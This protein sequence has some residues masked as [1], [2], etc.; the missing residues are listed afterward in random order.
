MSQGEFSVEDLVVSPGMQLGVTPDGMYELSLCD[1]LGSGVMRGKALSPYAFAATVDFTCY[2]CP[3]M[4]SKTTADTRWLADGVWFSINLCL[5]GRC[6]VDI[7]GRGFA[8]VAAGDVCV[9]YSR[10]FPSE[11]RYPLGY[12]R[13]V[14]VFVN[15]SIV[16]EPLF[17]LTNM[18]N[19]SLKEMAQAA[20]FAAVLAG[21]DELIACMRRLGDALYPFDEVRSQYELLGLLLGLQRRDLAHA[22]PHVILTR[23]QMDM[24]RAVH[25]EIEEG[26][27]MPHDAR[28]LAESFGVSA[29]TLNGYFSGVYGLTIAA[30]VRKRRMEEAS[31]LLRKGSS[32]VD[33][34]LGVGYANPSKFATAFKREFG[35]SP[36][37]WKR[38]CLFAAD[39][40]F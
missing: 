3:N 31:R 6:E 40:H 4:V 35:V 30:Y 29:T 32:V 2:R 21:D 20:G 16:S 39:D 8:V 7:P 10:E 11:F 13:G 38:R 37:D 9:S 34:A 18:Q 33:A 14:E 1:P 12:Y 25:D 19:Q 23:A 26:I 27:T 15:A 36:R 24:A 17:A 22:K 28:I 5:E